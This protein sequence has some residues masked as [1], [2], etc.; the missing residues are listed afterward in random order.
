MLLARRFSGC[1]SILLIGLF[2]LL[3]SGCTPDLTDDGAET[4]NSGETEYQGLPAALDDAHCDSETPPDG[5]TWAMSNDAVFVG[6]VDDVSP[7]TGAV[8]AD[9]GEDGSDIQDSC[10]GTVNNGLALEL[11]VDEVL[12]GSEIEETDAISVKIGFGQLQS[13]NPFP[14]LED[15]ELVWN[16]DNE[17]RISEGMSIGMGVRFHSGHDEWS[18]MGGPIFQIDGNT[19]LEFQDY[20]LECMVAPDMW[21]G[22]DIDELRDAVSGCDESAEADDRYDLMH[23]LWAEPPENSVAGV[24][25]N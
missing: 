19:G 10:S 9:S 14:S 5:C 25:I 3:S 11:T 2:V 1:T 22:F 4:D 20:R 8:V 6:T 24:C 7:I 15:G 13:W 23:N 16:G 18:L 21:D 12:L 17:G